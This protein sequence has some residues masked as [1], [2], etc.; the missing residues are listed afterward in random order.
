MKIGCVREIK[1]HEYRVA[2]TPAGVEELRADGHE[3]LMEAGAGEGSGLGDELYADA[4]ATLVDGCEGVWA[5]A[6]MVLKVK[7]PQE[8]EWA[9]MRPGQTLFT[10]FHL[11]ADR[12]LT[13]GVLATGSHCIA[14]ETLAVDRRLPLLEPMSEVAGRLAIQAGAR[15]LEK[16][17]GGSG[18]LLGGV[19]GVRPARVLV[20]GGGTVGTQSARMAAGLG[21]DVVICDV[22]HARMAY[23]DE[24]LPANCTTLW[25]SRRA[26]REELAAADLVV[27]A[28][29]IPGAAAPKLVQRADLE[30]LRSGS[31][32]V[33]VAID[34]GGCFETSRPTT[35]TDP[36][37][38][39]DGVVHYCVANMP[40]AVPRTSTLA[41][42]SAT[43]PWARRLAS[44]GVAA[45]VRGSEPLALAA[46]SIGGT[47][48]C[49]AV[50]RDF[51]MDWSPAVEAVGALA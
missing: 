6:E 7:E 32:I 28:V 29:L 33:D 15:S 48:T 51:G 34:Q 40:G 14:Y 21:A 43:L 18:V 31:V 13:E 20:L 16:P 41:L 46:N 38:V 17:V 8:V 50:A 26:I 11:A 27:G 1:T 9:R 3:V 35:H 2:L 39:V 19:P 44:E 4:G 10:Y 24:V 49:E 5:E 47:L 30:L 37:Y 36:T 42:T 25:S 45:A 23:L 22:N 12:R